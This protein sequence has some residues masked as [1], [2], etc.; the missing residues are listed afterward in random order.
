M[1]KH[2]VRIVGGD[3]R[4]TPIPVID[5]AGLRPTP[6]RV[7]ETLFNWLHH[8]WGGEFS[9]KRVLDLFAGTGALGFEAASRGVG[10]VQ[11]V[12]SHPPAVA[13]LRALRNRLN[14]LQVRIHAGDAR[15]FLERM[16][17]APYDLVMLDPPFGQGWVEALR[18]RLSSVLSPDGLLYIESETPLEAPDGFEPLRRARAGNVHFHLFRFAALQKTVNNPEDTPINQ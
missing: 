14:A 1:K 7:R 18:G 17:D 12:E 5:A 9:G 4:K 13:A 11:M 2:V 15:V 6:D 8:F 3:Y 16:N 10:H